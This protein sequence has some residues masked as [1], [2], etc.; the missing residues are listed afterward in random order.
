M[1]PSNALHAISDRANRLLLRFGAPREFAIVSN[2]CWGAGFY[3]DLGRAYNTPFVG[4]M[5]PPE[6]YLRL[7]AGWPDALY[8]P[9]RFLPKSRY[10][11]WEIRCPV[12]EIA[13]SEIHFMHHK[14]EAEAREKWTRRLARFPRDAATW[15]FKFCDHHVGS[16][17]RAEELLYQFAALPLAHKICFLA[18]REPALDC[19]I[20]LPECLPG[21]RVMDGHALYRV[22][23]RHFNAPAWLAGAPPR[24]SRLHGFSI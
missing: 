9:L 21:G 13:G 4:T 11:S 22:S 12:A 5:V 19:G 6:C 17:L 20:V 3:S 7:L 24:A 1:R 23:L 8:E 18:R 14:S 16:P 2:N 15:R 10:M